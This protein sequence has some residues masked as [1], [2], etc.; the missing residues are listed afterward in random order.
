MFLAINFQAKALES[1]YAKE[2]KLRKESEEA[3]VKEKEDHQRTRKQW[4][5]DRLI[6]MDQRL[7]QQI[8][9]SN[10]DNKIKEMNDEILTAVEQCKEY[11]K[12]RDE[13][14]L[15]RDIVLKIAEEISKFQAGD[16]E[17]DIALKIAEELSKRQA[18]DASTI[19]MGQ[20]LSVFSLSEIKE[21]TRNFDPSFKIGEGGYGSIYKG[22]LR[23]TPVA[24]KV[25]NPDSMQGPLEFKQE[26]RA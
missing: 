26:V 5:E 11:K 24:I 8:Q 15:E 3:L 6:T 20:F 9:S 22:V 2:L 12:E 23:Y 21:A 17:I 14:E 16:L 1:L 13:L 19:H 18:E 4:D 7:L 25:L 10:F